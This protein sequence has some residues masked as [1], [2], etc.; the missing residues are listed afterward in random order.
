MTTVDLTLVRGDAAQYD[1]TILNSQGSPVDL[2]G[3]V[4]KFGVKKYLSDPNSSAIV[5][6]RSY[7]DAEVEITAAASG[8]CSVY[9]LPE[10]TIP[11]TPGTLQWEVE[12]TRQ[13]AAVTGTGTLAVTAN[14][15]VVACTGVNMALIKPGQV[16]VPAG[17][18]PENNIPVTVVS[19]DEAGN[20]F[21]TD[22]TGWT[23]Q[24]GITFSAKR[25][26]R[27]TPDGLSGTF[28]LVADVVQ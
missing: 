23:T 10:D 5:L 22:Y 18:G 11:K 27:H 3:A 26:D 15:G 20:T 1:L 7:D 9:V 6:K 13:G 8:R 12:V 16:I 2:T 14:S 17:T 21:T 25:G 19:V 4:V 28:F 24:G